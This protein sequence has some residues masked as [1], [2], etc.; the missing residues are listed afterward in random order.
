MDTYYGIH[1]K[2]EVVG[3]MRLSANSFTPSENRRRLVVNAEG[4]VSSSAPVVP[5]DPAPTSLAAP[6][7]VPPDPVVLAPAVL[8]ATPVPALTPSPPV[9][10]PG[11][12]SPSPAVLAAACS[13]SKKIA[14]NVL[15][16]GVFDA[17]TVPASAVLSSAAVG[18][19]SPI[20]V[21]T[22]AILGVRLDVW[23]NKI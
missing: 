8:D 14:K 16:R 13:K 2:S 12:A 20:V 9:V 18:A 17:T 11:P 3:G 6:P 22:G 23:W 4:P 7:V 21:Y 15:Y 5:P 10:F 1:S 19:L